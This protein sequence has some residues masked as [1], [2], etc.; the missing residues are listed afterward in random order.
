MLLE[1]RYRSVLRMLPATYRAEREEEMVS[2]FMEVCGDVPD[3]EN[4]RPR[5]GEIASVLGLAVRLRLGGAG[6]GPR[7]A[8]WG[9]AVRLVALLGLAFQSVLGLFGLFALVNLG[10]G[11]EGPGVFGAPESGLRLSW[12]LTGVESVLWVTAFVALTRGGVRQAK[13]A[14]GVAT[15]SVL[16]ELA[17]T[18]DPP[19]LA[20]NVAVGLLTVV[21]TLALFA[22]YHRDAPALRLAW[23]QAVAP[24]AGGVILV[25]LT[26][27]ALV[28]LA[29]APWMWRWTDSIGMA[30]LAIALGAGMCL[31]RGGSA[32]VRLG[33]AMLA[34]V[35][36]LARL[37]CLMGP[38]GDPENVVRI[39]DAAQ[40][41]LLAVI[42]LVLAVSGVRA[43]PSVRH[44]SAAPATFRP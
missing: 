18:A 42:V 9:A 20:W 12:I 30:T 44:A 34:G 28:S 7:F 31:A 2:A 5:W 38:S 41:V 6:A 21:P 17:T 27:L 26:R 13:V 23:W 25:G 29:D 39:S 10:L 19:R 22:A 3:E 15:A 16:A 43:L 8:V 33:L 37:A 24:P 36:L 1:R 11:S 40:C 35:T 14:A 32:P 4:P